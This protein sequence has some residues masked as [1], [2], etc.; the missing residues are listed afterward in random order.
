M[1]AVVASEV[2]KYAVRKN[3][4]AKSCLEDY[5]PQCRIIIRVRD[6]KMTLM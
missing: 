6:A 1:F 4:I 3:L 2:G 5:H